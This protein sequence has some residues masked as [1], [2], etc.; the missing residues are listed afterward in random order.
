[1]QTSSFGFSKDFS[2]DLSS[3]VF[4]KPGLNNQLFRHLQE[5]SRHENLIWIRL[6]TPIS[7]DK[8]GRGWS[9]WLAVALDSSHRLLVIYTSCCACI[10]VDLGHPLWPAR[11]TAVSQVLSFYCTSFMQCRQV[12]THCVQPS[13]LLHS[14]REITEFVQQSAFLGTKAVFIYL[15]IFE[16][17]NLFSLA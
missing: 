17:R 4:F 15:F 9:P 2:A 8:K 5:K 16:D 11:D 1:M 3:E 6:Y 12:F 13:P 7:R 14:L 10:Q